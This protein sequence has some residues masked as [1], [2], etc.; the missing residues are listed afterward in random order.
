MIP[1]QIHDPCQGHASCS[2]YTRS[3][4]EPIRAAQDRRHSSDVEL[5]R[6][7]RRAAGARRG[8]EEGQRRRP[9]GAERSR[10]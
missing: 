4:H 10:A 7:G 2:A 1:A 3:T 9:R 8:E 5:A 6:H